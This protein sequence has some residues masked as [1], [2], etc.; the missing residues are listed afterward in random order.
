[1]AGPPAQAT[2]AT[3]G[4][5]AMA[6]LPVERQDRVATVLVVAG[7]VAQDDPVF[8]LRRAYQRH[9]DLE[10]GPWR[11]PSQAARTVRRPHRAARA[12]FVDD[13]LPV[14]DRQGFHRQG[15]QDRDE[16]AWHCADVVQVEPHARPGMVGGEG[17][18]V[19][20]DLALDRRRRARGHEHEGRDR[21]GDDTCH[22]DDLGLHG[23]E[24]LGVS[25]CYLRPYWPGPVSYTHLTLPT[26]YS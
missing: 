20:L 10:D 3:I 24:T 26:I 23:W 25:A 1:M 16:V 7:S 9:F 4:A 8:G 22:L 2:R 12:T 19:I 14:L 17:D 21:D 5:V 11:D 6:R 18:P 13:D 15:G